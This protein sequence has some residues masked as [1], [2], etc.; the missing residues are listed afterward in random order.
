MKYKFVIAALSCIALA[1]CTNAVD[2]GLVYPHSNSMFLFTKNHQKTNAE[3]KKEYQTSSTPVTLS[4]KQSGSATNFKQTGLIRERVFI[5]A[6]YGKVW[7]ALLKFAEMNNFHI[8][9]ADLQEGFL[10]IDISST[11]AQYYSSTVPKAISL[12]TQDH[13]AFNGAAAWNFHMVIFA[14]RANNKTL[15]EFIPKYYVITSQANN[16]E[17]MV[18]SNGYFERKCVGFVRKEVQSY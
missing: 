1:S 12:Y 2:S 16:A 11:A 13:S 18:K 4:E 6:S 17:Y 15:V 9:K 10:K 5:N 8:M 7:Q 14:S 3:L